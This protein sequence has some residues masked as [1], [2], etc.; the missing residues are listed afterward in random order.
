V[1]FWVGDEHGVLRNLRDVLFHLLNGDDE[2]PLVKLI[3]LLVGP[4]A[5]LAHRPDLV[6]QLFPPFLSI[7][8]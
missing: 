5:E 3:H 4:L 2:A 1:W 6:L 8:E 7:A